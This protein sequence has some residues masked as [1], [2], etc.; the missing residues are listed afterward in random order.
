M[1][2]SERASQH[3]FIGVS[4]LLFAGSAAIT[5]G[6]CMSMSATGDMPMPGG[7]AMSAAWTRMPEQTWAGAAAS[8][9]G[10]W[11]VMMV[12]MMLPSLAPKLW[13]FRQE[14]ARSGEARLGRLTAL[15]AAG[16]FGVWTVF[17]IAAFPLGALLAAI[18]MRQPALA[19]AVPA[20]VGMV[21]VMAG[22]FQLTAYKAR[23]LACCAEISVRA[24]AVSADAGSAWRHGVRL[25]LLCGRC[26]VNL[27][28]VQLVIGVMDLR[29]M[30][31]VT[32]A[33]T[34]ER[35]APVGGVVARVIGTVAVAGGV[36]L[37]A[38]AAWLG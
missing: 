11:I 28:I 13:R 10:M 4:A 5:I 8:F 12:P 24:G 26:C 38:R 32:A 21:V 19:R 22:S 23:Q 35:L 16:Y 37:V 15:A 18:E 2:T 14:V 27:M 33:I 20:V 25:G 29:V 3:T 34:V 30:A 9:L 7:W 31:A 36:L 17:G 6:W 1:A